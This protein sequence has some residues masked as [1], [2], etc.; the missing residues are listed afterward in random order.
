MAESKYSGLK[1]VEFSLAGANSWGVGSDKLLDASP[2]DSNEVN[3]AQTADGRNIYAGEKVTKEYHISDTSLF[4]ALSGYMKNDSEVD[5]R[6]TDIEGNVNIVATG[7]SI[8]VQKKSSSKVGE[9]SHIIV[10][11]EGYKI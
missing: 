2:G 9:R 1:K 6:E 11:C 10:K 7:C 3:S 5:V 4:T 8:I